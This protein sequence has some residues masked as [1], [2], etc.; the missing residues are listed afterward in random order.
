[1][2]ELT[3]QKRCYEILRIAIPAIVA[4]TVLRTQDAVNLVFLGHLDGDKNLIAGIGLGFNYLALM[5]MMVI[6]G[7]LMAMDTL[8]S[9]S[10]G[11][12]NLELCGVYL[13][14]SRFVMS[15]L[16]IPMV[17]LSFFVERIYVSWGLDPIASNFA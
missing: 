14:R 17:I 4:S 15:L 16:Y 12:G 10:K 5:G 1:M 6:S 3:W 7:L 11:A 9:Q 8:V 13:N 2:S